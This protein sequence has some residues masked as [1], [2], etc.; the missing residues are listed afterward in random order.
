MNR[1]AWA[2]VAG[3]AGAEG[4]MH[5]NRAAFDRHRIVPRMLRGSE[6]RDLQVRLFDR[7]FP[8][9]FFLAPIGVLDLVHQSA[10]VAAASAAAAEGVC[11]VASSQSSVPLEEIA[12]SAGEG[13][14]WFQL[15]WPSSNDLMASFVERAESA[16]YEAI[17]VTVDTTELGWRPRDLDLGYLPFAR[18]RGIANYVTDPVFMRLVDRSPHEKR[19]GVPPLAGWLTILELIKNWPA[20]W[21][22]AISDL[23]SVTRAIR[24]FTSLYSRPGLTWSDLSFLRSKTK[25]PILLKGILHPSDAI[26]AL[27]R[28]ADAIIVSNHGGR[29]VDGAVGALEVLPSVVRAVEDRVPVL[30]DSGV[31]TGADIIKALALGAKAVLIGR[32]YVYALAVGGETGVR[33]LIQNLAA[34][35]DLNLGLAGYG[36]IAE[37]SPQTLSERILGQDI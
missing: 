21:Q 19:S 22:S 20:G 8:L 25:L 16:D 23:G 31:R 4:T 24:C 13:P 10:D 30:F 14:R 27:D 35:I 29:Q 6:H 17:V 26:E 3:G 15:Y 1:K 2:Y 32:P 34:D 12:R 18:G 11:F 9:P 7:L 36:N 5:E 28:G 37:L 33:E